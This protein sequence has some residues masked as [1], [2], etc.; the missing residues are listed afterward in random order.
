[1][2]MIKIRNPNSGEERMINKVLGDEVTLAQAQDHAGYYDMD[3]H[4]FIP[5]C[6]ENDEVIGFVETSENSIL[7]EILT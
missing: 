5:K 2:V 4:Q 3:N 1:M 6:N 7:W